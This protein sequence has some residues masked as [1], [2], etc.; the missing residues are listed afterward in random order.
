MTFDVEHFIYSCQLYNIYNILHKHSK[1]I[2]GLV[3]YMC[4]PNIFH[5]VGSNRIDIQTHTMDDARHTL[6]DTH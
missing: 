3:V 1:E 5:S 2:V 6:T 4:V